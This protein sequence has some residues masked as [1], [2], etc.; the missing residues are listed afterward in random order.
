MRIPFEVSADPFYS[1]ENQKVL[2][3]SIKQLEEGHGM[4]HELVEV[5]K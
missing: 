3:R 2:A 1:I 4:E 5:G